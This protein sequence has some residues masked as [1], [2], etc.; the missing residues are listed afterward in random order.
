[1]N[2]LEEQKKSKIVNPISSDLNVLRNSIFSNLIIY[3]SKNLD[4][5]FKDVSLFEIGPIF[6]GSK[7]G[8]TRNC[9]WRFKCW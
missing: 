9:I 5:G 7:P 8:R 1:M 4:R 2:Y 6:Y 3:L